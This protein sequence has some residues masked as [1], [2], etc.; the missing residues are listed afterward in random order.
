MSVCLVTHHLNHW[1]SFWGVLYFPRLPRFLPP[2]LFRP[3]CASSVSISHSL[4]PNRHYLARPLEWPRWV[5]PPLPTTTPILSGFE[6]YNTPLL[7]SLARPGGGT[8]QCGNVDRLAKWLFPRQP[9]MVR[10]RKMRLLFAGIFLAFLSAAAVAGLFF[11]LPILSGL[12]LF[13]VRWAAMLQARLKFDE[14]PSQRRRTGRAGVGEAC[15]WT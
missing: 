5:G 12:K 14:R 11:I 4:K 1:S 13:V 2:G 6:H 8:G 15:T 10:Y 7:I 3:L 9:R